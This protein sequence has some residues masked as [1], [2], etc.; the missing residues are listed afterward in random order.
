MIECVACLV[1]QTP[2]ITVS[3]WC[4]F[5]DLSLFCK[6]NFFNPPNLMASLVALVHSIINFVICLLE[7]HLFK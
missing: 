5:D 2:L 4:I 1:A 6:I 3:L 7:T